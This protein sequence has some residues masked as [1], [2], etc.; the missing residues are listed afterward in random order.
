VQSG[1]EGKISCILRLGIKKNYSN[2]LHVSSIVNPKISMQS[3]CRS[4]DNLPITKPKSFTLQKDSLLRF[5][6]IHKPCLC[7]AL[8]YPRIIHGHRLESRK[9]PS[10]CNS[11]KYSRGDHK[12]AGA[13]QWRVSRKLPL[14]MK[15]KFHVKTH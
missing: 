10:C 11:E 4:K 9:S 13:R 14:K 5:I 8:S 1:Q 15:T 6:S 3:S 12:A 7:K 2:R